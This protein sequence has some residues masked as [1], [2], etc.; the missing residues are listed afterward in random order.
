MVVGVHLHTPKTLE[1]YFMVTPSLSLS[2]F[3]SLSLT[4][5]LPPSLSHFV[6]LSLPLSF[7][8]GHSLSLSLSFIRS[9]LLLNF[10]L[11][12]FPNVKNVFRFRWHLLYFSLKL[13]LTN[14]DVLKGFFVYLI[15]PQNHVLGSST[16]VRF[17]L[18][19]QRIRIKN[20]FVNLCVGWA[21]ICGWESQTK[22]V[23]LLERGGGVGSLLVHLS[24]RRIEKKMPTKRTFCFVIIS[25]VFVFW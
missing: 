15:S 16:N 21:D 17:F 18:S 2:F 23:F 8:L 25:E 10:L 3:L 20:D 7:S 14:L 1:T 19:F 22:Q 13:F 9:G 5:S 6:S 11:L 12:H 24:K 4:L